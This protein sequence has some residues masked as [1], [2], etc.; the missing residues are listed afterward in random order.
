MKTFVTGTAGI[1]S[2][3]LAPVFSTAL[4]L[5]AGAPILAA[6]V[7]P[8][9][10]SAFV[11]SIGVNTHV[12]RGGPYGNRTTF[13]NA[14]GDLGV[15][16]VRD[17]VDP[18]N[19][20][21][22]DYLKTLNTNLGIK[23]TII[24]DWGP[25]SLST[26]G[27]SN[28]L[29]TQ[30]NI[31]RDRLG[32]S[33]IAGITGPNEPNLKPN[34]TWAG[35]TRTW[36]K[37]LWSLTRT[38]SSY[39]ALSG[40]PIIAPAIAGDTRAASRTTL[41]SLF[42][43]AGE[44]IENYISNAAMHPYPSAGRPPEI[45]ETIIAELT[46]NRELYP[47]KPFVVTET[48]YH[49]AV[50]GGGAAS[51]T[52]AGI[53]APRLFLDYFGYRGIT[54]TFWYELF[55]EDFG[56][57]GISTSNAEENFGLFRNNGSR[58]PAG[59]AVKNLVAL[60]GGSGTPTLSALDYTLSNSNVRHVLL[61]KSNGDYFLAVWLP[62]YVSRWYEIPA[63]DENP[64]DQSCT[65]TLTSAKTLT[66]YDNLDTT[67]STAN[68]GNGTTFNFTVSERVKLIKI[69]S[70]STRYEF[71]NL[72]RQAIS[73]GDITSAINEAALSNGSSAHLAANATG[74]FATYG[75]SVPQAGTYR[76]LLG[77][78]KYTGRGIFQLAT[79]DSL[80]GTYTNRGAAQD[81]YNTGA[82]FPQLD[83]GTVTFSSAGTK[84]FRFTVTG[85]NSSSSGFG[86]TLDYVQLNPA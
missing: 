66:S 59:T 17:G 54:R 16:H 32:A 58:K 42:T 68:L 67:L 81:T 72:T 60:L 3:R 4:V 74:D 45:N 47:T 49:N 1:R 36:M 61:R 79:S 75:V 27:S 34:S 38:N 77:V 33:M 25:N 35:D 11:D 65:L 85:K 43:N 63:V 6:P 84:S 14:L 46:G 56:T 15:K 20:A 12:E 10:A 78:K 64:A 2:T 23:S 26:W 7:T 80:S 82:T 76:I 44:N 62:T 22:S 52:A 13:S 40:I 39:S 37:N 48:G 9:S 86:V 24:T 19:P 55:D 51:E 69:A 31:I 5:L 53:Y 70:S 57:S 18:N 8:K 30:L 28:P 41:K 21:A 73:S 83:L 29:G 71:E 50:S